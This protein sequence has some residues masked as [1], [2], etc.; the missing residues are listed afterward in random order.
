[1]TTRQV[2]IYPVNA[3]EFPA[4]PADWFSRTRKFS[5]GLVQDI[6]AEA[7]PEDET[8][9]VLSVSGDCQFKTAG[10]QLLAGQVDEEKLRR[11][12]LIRAAAEDRK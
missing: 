11:L 7:Q 8:L 1:M 12:E 3:N 2:V 10:D 4:L 9:A 6:G 5:P